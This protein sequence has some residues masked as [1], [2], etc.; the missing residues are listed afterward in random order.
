MDKNR[1]QGSVGQQ[2]DTAVASGKTNDDAPSVST[3]I[4]LGD[5]TRTQG[6]MKSLRL[7]LNNQ[8]VVQ[9]EDIASGVSDAGRKFKLGEL[10]QANQD[11][12]RL[13]AAFGQRTNQWENQARNLEQ[14]MKMQAAKNPKSISIDAMNR[15]KAEQTAVRTRIRTA[16]VLFRRL[17]Q[18]LDL[19]FT[20]SQRRPAAINTE[21]PVD[22]P[23][24]FLVAFENAS[25]SQRS[26]IVKTFF[27]IESKLTVY[28]TK[29]MTSGYDIRFDPVPPLNRLYFLAQTAQVIRLEKLSDPVVLQDVKGATQIDMKLVEFVKHVQSG[30]WLLKPTTDIRQIREDAV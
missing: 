13:Y 19:A 27:E 9:V 15:M 30:V 28:V 20:N 22:L 16:E 5:F 7:L 10:E 21:P 11:L 14:Q 25:T 24:K 1:A 18:G 4:N 23:P 29:N 17:Q 6:L 26:E 8:P 2:L 3:E 12:A